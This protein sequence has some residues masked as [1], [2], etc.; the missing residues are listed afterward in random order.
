MCSVLKG[1]AEY[2]FFNRTYLYWYHTV[3]NGRPMTAKPSLLTT[4]LLLPPYFEKAVFDSLRLGRRRVRFRSM[5]E[6]ECGR[7][8]S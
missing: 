7:S 5:L 1:L 6:P 4:F 3:A 8:R 2:P